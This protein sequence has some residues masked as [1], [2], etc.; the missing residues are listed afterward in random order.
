[1]SKFLSYIYKKYKCDIIICNIHEQNKY[2]D[3]CDYDIIVSEFKNIRIRYQLNNLFYEI[4]TD[5]REEDV[6]DI[7]SIIKQLLIAET[8]IK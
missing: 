2:I 5:H 6:G 8:E 4:E 1:M 3:E 7:Y